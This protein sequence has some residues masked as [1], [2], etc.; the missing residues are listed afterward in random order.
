MPDSPAPASIAFCVTGL[1]AGG[2]ERMLVEL[3]TRLDRRSFAPTV[4]SLAAR[5]VKGEP[6]AA[7]LEACGIPVHFLDARST[8]NA[9][10]TYRRLCSL[11]RSVR[12]RLVQ[13]WLW[14]ANVLGALAARRVGI[15]VVTGLRV[16]EPARRWR[17]WLERVVT[18]A[19]LRHVA[20]GEGVKR[21]A[22]NRVGLEAS[23]IDVIP[24]GVKIFSGEAA[25]LRQ[26]GIPD[27]RKALAFVGRLDKQKGIDWLVEQLPS[28]L[29]RL[30]RHDVLIVGDG[31]LMTT[32]ARRISQLKIAD[33][34][35]TIGWLADPRPLLAAADLLL[36]P[37]RWE[38]MPNVLLEAMAMCRPVVAMD[39]EGVSELLASDDQVV[40]AGDLQAFIERTITIATNTAQRESLGNRNRHRAIEQFSLDRMVSSY[41]SFYR[42]ILMR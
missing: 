28:L 41:E 8:W 21:F 19:A 4:I 33:R 37:S 23:K 32:I 24:N 15:A 13:T 7:R 20:V 1:E 10:R 2:A 9:P 5:S 22:I 25:D 31:P 36:L 26:F 14:H 35:H 27:S 12:P 34:V 30:P 29:K 39:V 40:P 6:L 11:L 16:A 17:W 18:R 38:G 3:V 42:T